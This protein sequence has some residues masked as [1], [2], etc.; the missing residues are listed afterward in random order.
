MD[1]DKTKM[2]EQSLRAGGE[3]SR[4]A[5]AERHGGSAPGGRRSLACRGKELPL[6]ERTL[7]MGILNVTPDSFSDG[8]R[9]N[10]LEA[11]VSRARQLV[12]EGADIIDIGGESTRP[13]F[14][15]LSLE[16]ELERVVPII[17]ALAREVDVVL[18]V[19]TYK[20]EVGRRA[21]E[22]GAHMLNDIWGCKLDPEMAKVAAATGSPI[23]LM[24]NRTN[25]DYTD[26]LTDVRRDLLESVDIA[27]RAGVL[28]EQIV[29]DPG[30]GFVKSHEQNLE[31]IGRLDSL[32]ELGYPILLGTSRK[33]VI[34][35]TLNLPVDQLVEGTV[36]TTVLG[37]A[38][39]C[40]IVRVHDVAA[41]KRAAVMAD[42]ILREA[43]GN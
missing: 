21:L 34:R 5:G 42:A 35:H 7:I 13:G 20:A 38:Q 37:I 8:G 16:E 19:D 6:G 31:L 41:N 17:E 1:G 33:R 24:H 12:E 30:I 39:G 28:G 27:R 22:A 26:F 15:P 40:Q 23:I 10:K 18:S 11:A 25:T 32:A 4:T 14:E 2:I 29:L 9:Y 43:R 3:N 36:A